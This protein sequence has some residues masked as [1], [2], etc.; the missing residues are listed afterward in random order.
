MYHCYWPKGII[1]NSLQHHSDIFHSLWWVFVC[2]RRQPIWPLLDGILH[3]FIAFEGSVTQKFVQYWKQ[4]KIT[5]GPILD[6]A[7]SSETS[8]PK[9]WNI[10]YSLARTV[11]NFWTTLVIRNGPYSNILIYAKFFIN[12]PNYSSPY[13]SRFEEYELD[14]TI[15][16]LQSLTMNKKYTQMHLKKTLTSFTSRDAPHA[17]FLL[18]TYGKYAY[19]IAQKLYLVQ[20]KRFVATTTALSIISTPNM[21]VQ[22]S[23]SLQFIH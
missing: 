13:T 22:W 23:L 8:H 17:A 18:A 7:G 19:R 3:F 5:W 21:F 9:S 15:N 1:P 2:L 11:L 14:D 20:L 6:Y 4:V 16:K 12:L 10:V